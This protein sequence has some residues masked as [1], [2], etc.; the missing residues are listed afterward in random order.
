[1]RL[2]SASGLGGLL[3]EDLLQRISGRGEVGQP[4][5]DVLARQHHA[6]GA[7]V[8]SCV[9]RGLNIVG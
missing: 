9:Q 1:M 7:R 2:L 3:R 4:H 5:L 6:V 8:E